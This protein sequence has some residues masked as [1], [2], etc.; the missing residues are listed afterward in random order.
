[1]ED[2]DSRRLFE[3]EDEYSS[4]PLKIQGESLRHYSKFEYGMGKGGR[5]SL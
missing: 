2:E 4:K 5:A 3:D 1:M